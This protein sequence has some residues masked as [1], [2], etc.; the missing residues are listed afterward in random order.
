[1]SIPPGGIDFA[2]TIH[3]SLDDEISRMGV[4]RSGEGTKRRGS[5]G[6]TLGGRRLTR[7]MLRFVISRREIAPRCAIGVA[8][9]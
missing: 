4:L 6:S 3:E 9:R 5:H 7:R 1:M 8:A 2:R